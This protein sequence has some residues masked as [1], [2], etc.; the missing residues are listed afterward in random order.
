MIDNG[1]QEYRAGS[2]YDEMSMDD[3]R[4]MVESIQ[5]KEESKGEAEED[6]ILMQTKA[7]LASLKQDK[8]D[9][10]DEEEARKQ[11]E[12]RDKMAA[13]GTM[14]DKAYEVRDNNR[15]LDQE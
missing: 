10:E 7:L 2:M 11:K 12:I 3:A 4:S 6:E 9:V 8:D 1:L 13:L 5:E 14:I 15:N